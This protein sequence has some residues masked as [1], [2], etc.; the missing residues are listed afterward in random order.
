MLQ[1]N[2]FV[3]RWIPFKL[4]SLFN[5]IISTIAKMASDTFTAF[6]SAIS[7]K[8]WAAAKELVAPSVSADSKAL[9]TDEFIQHRQSYTAEASSNLDTLVVDN[10]GTKIAARIIHRAK[11]P[12][13]ELVFCTV[14]N[15]RITR[16]DSLDDKEEAGAAAAPWGCERYQDG[17]DGVADLKEFYTDYIHTINTL[18]MKQGLGKYCH[19]EVTH[20]QRTYSLDEYREMIESSFDEISGLHFA[21]VDI[22]TNAQTQQIA[23]QLG[24]RGKPVKPFRGVQPN[25]RGVKFGEHVFYQLHAGKIATMASLLDMT[26]Y[27]QCMSG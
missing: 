25:G 20:S 11:V 14:V 6:L 19:G 27:K 22:V 16:Y 12:W 4:A 5:H 15:D 17:A 9:T 21:V 13:S 3:S 7:D 23:A 26:S 8:N 2:R 10:G 1:H 24:F 18:T